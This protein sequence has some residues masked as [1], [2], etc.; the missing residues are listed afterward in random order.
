MGS[1]SART[2]AATETFMSARRTSADTPAKAFML[3]GDSP[4]DAATETFMSARIAASKSAGEKALMRTTDTLAK[5]TAKAFVSAGDDTTVA[6]EETFV[7]TDKGASGAIAEALVCTVVIGVEQCRLGKAPLHAELADLSIRSY[8]GHLQAP[9]N[10][11][12]FL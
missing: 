3:A 12:L 6:F 1:R 7:T 10:S 2:D 4:A 9:Y 5:A 11:A 8:I